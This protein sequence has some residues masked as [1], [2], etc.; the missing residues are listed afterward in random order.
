M[1]EI[2]NKSRLSK[3]LGKSQ[4]TLTEW[5]KDGMP[6]AKT[7]DRK[8]QSNTYDTAAVIEWMIRRA[9]DT[10]TAM[11][12]AKLR[13][14]EAEAEM[15][16]LKVKEKKEELIPL[17][18]MKHLMSGVF[19][20]CRARVLSIP[21]RIAPIVATHRDPKKIQKVLEQ[22]CAEA[23]TDLANYDPETHDK[24]ARS[25]TGSSKGSRAATTA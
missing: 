12:R 1:G 14:T 4:F 21:S 13:L 3:I 22:A 16:E 2:V 17:D 6:I 25:R 5:Q 7:A 11:E 19:A 24:A 9:S 20:S 15:A 8:G 23:L 10:S 18:R